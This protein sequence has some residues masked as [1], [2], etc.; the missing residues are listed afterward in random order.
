MPPLRRMTF[1]LELDQVRPIVAGLDA[2]LRPTAVSR[3]HGG[4]TEVYRI[5]LAGAEPIVLKLYP[6]EPVWSPGKEVLV[7]GWLAAWGELPAPRWLRVDESREALPWRYALTTWLP[8]ETVRSL[9]DEPDVLGLYREM[10]AWLRRLHRLPMEGYGYVLDQGVVSPRATNGD[11]VAAAF[12]SAFREFVERSG[13]A[14][15]ASRLERAVQP[16][17]PL[18]SHSAGSFFAHD[19][20]QPGN[21]LAARKD[22]T[23]A[24]T[25][26]LD[27]GNARAADPLF[28]LAKALF[29]CTHEDPRSPGPLLEGYGEIDHPDVEGVLW[30]YTLY[31][32][33][34]MWIFLTRI[35]VG[36]GG[37]PADLLRDLTSMA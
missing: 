12:E 25:G 35:G 30:L 8:G 20:F 14:A 33:L 10:G 23:L 29:C 4:S 6:D 18:A 11:Y 37:G 34:V 16:R 24:L 15:L 22:G 1:D 3:L 28:D 31:H 32:R 5:D 7:A 17:L 2:A 36:P 19:D 13:E 9:K 27:F 26:L 21:L